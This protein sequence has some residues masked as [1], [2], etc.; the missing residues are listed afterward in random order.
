MADTIKHAG[1]S[2]SWEAE[3]DAD[4]RAPWEEHDG[5]GP[6]RGTAK[7]SFTSRYR[8]GDKKPGERVLW[9]ERGEFLLY[10]W[11]GAMKLARA[12]GW[13]MP[14]DDRAEFIAKHGREPTR[15]EQCAAAVQSDFDFLRRYCDGQEYWQSLCVTLLDVEGEPV[16]QFREYL[17]GIL[18]ADD[19]Y[20]E[21]EAVSLADH[22]AAQ[23]KQ[24]LGRK[25][26]LTLKHGAR[27]ERVR[28]RN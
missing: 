16:E 20:L 14:A 5:H 12:D 4:M 26:I 15:G 8:P 28:V 1:F 21:S 11:Q 27:V 24:Q 3:H 2:F 6:V 13:G 18:G 23:V 7:E 17:G 25:K 9:G 19:A 22:I 10:D